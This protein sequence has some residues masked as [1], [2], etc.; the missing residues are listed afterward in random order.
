[1]AQYLSITLQYYNTLVL[2]CQKYSTL[3]IYYLPPTVYICL[4]SPSKLLNPGNQ[5]HLTSKTVGSAH[6]QT[7]LNSASLNSPLFQ[8]F[9]SYLHPSDPPCPSPAFCIS[10]P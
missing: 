7:N 8:V 6:E 5:C 2:P 3:S 10:V 4:H 1:M 9:P